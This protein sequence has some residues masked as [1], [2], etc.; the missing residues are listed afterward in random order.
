MNSRPKQAVSMQHLRRMLGQNVNKTRYNMHELIQDSVM[1]V[2]SKAT[3]SNVKACMH[4]FAALC[5]KSKTYLVR[6]G[7]S[8]ASLPSDTKQ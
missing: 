2:P 6:N 4:N 8:R 1:N 7:Q 5:Y 3:P